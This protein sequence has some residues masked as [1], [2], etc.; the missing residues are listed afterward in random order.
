MI[1]CKCLLMNFAEDLRWIPMYALTWPLPFTRTSQK[2]IML[3][4]Q[5]NSSIISE[6]EVWQA[7]KQIGPLKAPGRYGMHAIFYQ[8]C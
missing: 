1:F 6:T 8:K 3:G 2:N 5:Y 4:Y 7:V